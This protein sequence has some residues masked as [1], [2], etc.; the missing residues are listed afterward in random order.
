[1]EIY[2]YTDSAVGIRVE[3]TGEWID[4]SHLSEWMRFWGDLSIEFVWMD[5]DVDQAVS[6]YADTLM[7]HLQP[8]DPEVPTIADAPVVMFQKISRSGKN[9]RWRS[10]VREF[11]MSR[12]HE[13]WWMKTRMIVKSDVVLLTAMCACGKARIEDMGHV[14]VELEAGLAVEIP[15]GRQLQRGQDE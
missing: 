6:G 9:G 12:P 15:L 3:A 8:G 5:V 11:G 4:Q 14:R 7:P 13:H 1:M 10:Y 2:T